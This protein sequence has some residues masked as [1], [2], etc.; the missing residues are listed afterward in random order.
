M[1]KRPV[2]ILASRAPRARRP[3]PRLLASAEALGVTRIA[4][5]TGL[6]RSGVEVA[7]AVRPLGHVL[8]VA[9]GKGTSFREAARG[10]VLEAAELSAAEAPERAFLRFG[11]S[12]ELV[13]QGARVVPPEALGA[14]GP[15]AGARMA[16]VEG[17]EILSGRSTWVPAS[18]V[19]CPPGGGAFLGPAVAPWTS[20][21]MGAYWSRGPALR[22]ALLEAAERDRLARALPRGFTA[23]SVA[24]HLLD[25]GAVGLAAPRALALA[26]RIA[27]RGFEVFLLDLSAPGDVPLAAALLAD[28]AGGPVPLSAGYAAALDLERA[29]RAAILE[30]AQSRLTDIHG[31][32]EDVAHAD[33]GAMDALVRLCQR[34][35]PR[36]RLAFPARLPSGAGPASIR[37]LARRVGRAVVAVDLP[38]PAAGVH[39]VKVVAAGLERSGLL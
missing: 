24:A 9:N 23:R 7:C 39:V 37:A 21:G 27:A 28:R 8:Q 3:G 12:R 26:D 25:R 11:S 31:A 35:R 13:A 4:R 36:R 30:A 29:L 16:W 22:H 1:Y 18:A 10:A 38:S 17:R 20:N 19:F 14:E 5:V 6:D 2:E 32:R 34:A 33:P 15:L